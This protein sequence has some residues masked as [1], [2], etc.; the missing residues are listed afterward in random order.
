MTEHLCDARLH[1]ADHVANLG[2]QCQQQIRDAGGPFALRPGGVADNYVRGR[3][4]LDLKIRYRN[5]EGKFR[6]L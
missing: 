3:V 5:A 4:G 2:E 6:G 1:D